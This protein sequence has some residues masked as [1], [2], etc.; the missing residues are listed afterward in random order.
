MSADQIRARETAPL[1]TRVGGFP[2]GEVAPSA[3]LDEGWPAQI[4]NPPPW[5]AHSAIA[6]LRKRTPEADAP[7]FRSTKR[8]TPPGH[9][10]YRRSAVLDPRCRDARVMQASRRE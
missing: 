5:L 1:R 9:A 2:M 4:R 3:R 7:G 6:F 10:L 8:F